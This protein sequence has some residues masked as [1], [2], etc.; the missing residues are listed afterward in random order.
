MSHNITV[1][2]GKSVRL[3]TAGKYCD[4]DIIITA[5]GSGGDGFVVCNSEAPS[6]KN[7]IAD[8]EQLRLSY[9]NATSLDGDSTFYR[10]TSLVS[11]DLPNITNIR[12]GAFEDCT[13]LTS[14]NVPNATSVGQRAFDSCTSLPSI[15]L[16]KVES[17]GVFA[18]SEC[19]SLQSISLPSATII[20][21][22]A[23]E[24]CTLLA[25]VNLPMAISIGE[26]AFHLC[27]SLP[28]IDLPNA[29]SIEQMAFLQCASLT[30]VNLPK[31]STIGLGAIA[32]CIA[33]AS[34][35]L[36]SATSVGQQA[37]AGCTSLDTLMLGN[38]ETVCGL[39]LTAVM[40]TKIATAEGMPTG[41]GFIYVP[42]AF[43]EQ[44][45]ANLT[46]Q[47]YMLLVY[48]GYSEAEAEYLAPYII[49]AI[50]RTIE[51]G[52]QA[53][54]FGLRNPLANFHG[55]TKEAIERFK[56]SYKTK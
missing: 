41:E 38:T 43:Y 24:E 40:G 52:A 35:N 6:R 4:R 53:T 2:G 20:E 9:P 19:T 16:P 44:Y 47:A 23:F 30:S 48:S 15:S 56:E 32:D 31:A 22:S 13:S 26:S 25:S 50:L 3:P 37:F 11:I 54:T 5:E 33:L 46:E 21:R 1:Q 34:V 45:M 12:A 17:V 8:L 49:S 55:F 10:C 51:G 42:E 39:N 14:V 36:P 7:T 28:S 27:T 29:T 18:F